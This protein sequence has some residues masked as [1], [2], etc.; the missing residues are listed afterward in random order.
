VKILYGVCGEGLGHTSRSRILIHYLQQ[1]NHEV[2]IIA[3]GKAYTILSKEFD[4]V[5]EVVSPKG[6]Y[7]GNQVRVLYTLLY[8][9]YQTI[10]RT[11]NSFIKVRQIIKTFQPDLL[12]TDAE[13]ISHLAARFSKIKRMCIDNPSALLYRKYTVKNW[14]YFSWLFLFFALKVSLFAADKYIIYDFS[15][16][17]INDP[18]VLFLKPLIQPGI[19]RQTPTSSDH[20]F[21][22]QTS[23]S[24]LSLFESLKKFDETFIIYGFNKEITDGNLVFKRFNED[25]FY[26]DIASAKAVVVNGGFTVISEA[27]FLKKPIFSLP[28]RHQ[29]E[30]VF[31][32]RCVERMGVGVSHKMFCEEDLRQFLLNLNSYQ[33]NL[34][35]YDA[36]NQDEILARIEQ[37]IRNVFIKKN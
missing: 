1:Q 20:I 6:F 19:R 12:I 33:E 26:H 10:V 16:E 23:L 3:G 8:T 22:Y 9:L 4:G 17:Q 31:N 34:Q 15:T 5:I 29:F 13:P 27:L 25:A 28:I 7:T 21:I 14:E 11:P 2:Y 30:Q 37:E 35:K 24:F 32:A 36:G 18:R